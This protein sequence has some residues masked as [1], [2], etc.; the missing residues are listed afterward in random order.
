[1]L[2]GCH[3]APK[4]GIEFDV[5]ADGSR[6][7]D[8]S[9]KKMKA[10]TLNLQPEKIY[11]VFT[12]LLP[13]D[14]F[15]VCGNLRSRK[16]I[17]IYS[18]KSHALIT[19]MIDRGTAP[20]Q[21]LSV[22][23]LT[24]GRTMDPSNLWVYDITLGKLFH[25]DILKAARDTGYRADREVVLPPELK[26]MVAPDAINDSL[27]V[28]TTYT[29]DDA[30]YI[31][32]NQTIVK[33]IGSLPQT[34]HSSYLSDPPETKFP[35]RAYVFKATSIRNPVTNKVAVFYNK[36]DLA[37]FYSNDSLVSTVQGPDRF[38]ALMQVKKLPAGFS[39]E[40]FEK[41]RYAYLS[42][43]YT[44]D[45][46]YALY[47]GQATADGSS[48]RIFVFDWNG[49]F[50]EELKLSRRVCKIAMNAQTRTLYC[51]DVGERAV[52]SAPVD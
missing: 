46:I 21:G 2:S 3:S 5:T 27:W 52:L 39:I 19:E 13:V 48:D 42:V 24:T 30:R 36:T 26:N 23:S 31:Y 29:W 1:M 45:K 35:N 50:Q 37:E 51:Y 6:V 15:L 12:T 11:G 4:S 18:L 33:K 47:S 34:S 43:T 40:D 16:L 10:R 20:R 41:T 44:K 25:L 17:G 49:S 22:A 32:A 9:P 28:A 7:R 14:S 38:G 8:L